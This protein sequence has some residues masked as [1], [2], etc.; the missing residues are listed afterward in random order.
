MFVRQ[1]SMRILETHQG[2]AF[3]VC[4]SAKCP[5]QNLP[6]DYFNL[7]TVCVLKLRYIKI[8]LI[9]SKP[10]RQVKIKF[11]FERH[12]VDDNFMGNFILKNFS[13][14]TKYCIIKKY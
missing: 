10:G 11:H 8:E 5:A 1:S 14:L 3:L 6:I 4:T 12:Y 7:Q 2:L 9:L 13:Q